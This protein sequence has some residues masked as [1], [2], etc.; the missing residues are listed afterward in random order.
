MPFSV[1]YQSVV[2][3]SI[4]PMSWKYHLIGP[5]VYTPWRLHLLISSLVLAIAILIMMFLPE[6]PKFLLS[7]G[8][9]SEAIQILQNIYS[10]NTGK[11]KDVLNYEVLINLKNQ[12]NFK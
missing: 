12:V 3:F 2:G 10:T 5:F 11:D 8:R 7:Q 6:S 1:I 9:Q 4:L